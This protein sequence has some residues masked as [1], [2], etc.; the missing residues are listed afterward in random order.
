MTKKATMLEKVNRYLEFRRGLGYR[1]RS[2]GWLLQK[3]G[4]FADAAGHR[5]P[6]TTELALR[7]ARLPEGAD[8]LY[9]A[10]RL[11]VVR[12][13]AKHLA[14]IES[15]TQIPPRGVLGRAH[16]RNAPYI[17]TEAELAALLAA[18][19][20]LAPRTGLRPKTYATL[21]GL[22]ACTGLR[23]SEA[24]RLTQADVDLGRAVLSIRQTKFNK[25]RLV[26]I[27]P[28]TVAP[29]RTYAKARHRLAAHP[30]CGRFFVSENGRP[31]TYQTVRT[32]FRK[33]CDSQQIVARA[34]G[35]PDSMIFG[36]LSPA[37]AW[38]GGIPVA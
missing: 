2:E 6:L 20:Q 3:F 18:A 21:I 36:I 4:A 8:R 33:L 7:W 12:C 29:L 31:L 19:R 38:K 14:A 37:A 30:Q 32:V 24:L 13:F 5:G 17:Y 1:L 22:L 9:W 23:I 27:H 35:V 15:D 34:G 16:R 11:E 25:S 26:P 10:R 28:T